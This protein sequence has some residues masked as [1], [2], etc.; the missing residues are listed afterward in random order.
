MLNSPGIPCAQAVQDSLSQGIQTSPVMEASPVQHIQDVYGSP[1]CGE[2]LTQH[3]IEEK[4]P[5]WE[6]ED[7]VKL[8]FSQYSRYP[9]PTDSTRNS[10][11][12]EET[13]VWRPFVVR[14]SNTREVNP[15]LGRRESVNIEG[16][17]LASYKQDTHMTPPQESVQ[18]NRGYGSSV[19]V[20]GGTFIPCRERFYP[21]RQ[22]N[23]VNRSS[24][25]R[26]GYRRG[27]D[28]T[29]YVVEDPLLDPCV[30]FEGQGPGGHNGDFVVQGQ[31]PSNFGVRDRNTVER[32]TNKHPVG[33]NP[34]G[35]G[36]IE[37]RASTGLLGSHVPQ[38]TGLV[39]NPCQTD[40]EASPNEKLPRRKQKEPDK[41]D[42]EKVEW[43]D[44][45]V[46]FE[47]VATWNGWTDLEKGLQ[48]ATCLRGKAQ[49]VLSELKPSQKSDYHTLT[50]VLAE[51]FNPP[52]RENVFRAMLRQRKR[53]PKESL[54][55][56]GCEVSRLAHKAYLKFPYEALDQVSREQFVRGLFDVDMKRYVDLQNPSSLEEAISLATQFESFDIREGHSPVAERGETRPSRGRSAH[57]Q[58]EEQPVEKK[59]KCTNEELASL[60]EQIEALIARE[61]KAEK[62]L[63]AIAELN[64]VVSKLTEQVESLTKIGLAKT[65]S[66]QSNWKNRPVRSRNQNNSNSIPKGNCFGC[67]QPGHYRNACPK[68]K[69]TRSKSESERQKTSQPKARTVIRKGLWLVP[70]T[71]EGVKVEM[72]V[73][74]GSDVALVDSK[75]Y[76]SIPA[77]ARP[78]LGP[79]TWSVDTTLDLQ[80]W[81]LVKL[82]FSY[83]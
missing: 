56:F 42:G 79:S 13:S 2:D 52:H 51:R 21:S 9:Q 54:M 22:G 16:T 50:S 80:L 19:N 65:K 41:Y 46:H 7:N 14:E 44:F 18:T 25:N 57:V 20:S 28:C 47:T 74:S 1:S 6:K 26:L 39:S 45:I 31:G 82:T 49:K 17:R 27:F 12:V 15:S 72:L 3:K 10:A 37:S 32:E 40:A 8:E 76:N 5:F 69:K 23:P 64:Q 33:S 63:K 78:S 81:R 55:D 29:G 11:N 48:L 70:G 66:Y 35:L 73:D 43:Q 38:G 83:N 77:A 53:L 60:R 24:G 62:A 68:S 71:V 30:E 75:F 4:V 67:G 34:S 36:G 61:S 58:A 59:D